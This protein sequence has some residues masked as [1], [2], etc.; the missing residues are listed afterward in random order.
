MRFL[1]R[2]LMARLLAYFLLLSLVP[3]AIA[4][5]AGYSSAQRSIVNHRKD[6]LN[7]IAIMMKE[8]VQHWVEDREQL[9]M[10]FKNVV[11]NYEV[12]TAYNGFQALE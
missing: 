8:E 3:L 12:A 5:Y 6:E 7:A 9:R 11:S 10:A 2:S 1:R 4:G